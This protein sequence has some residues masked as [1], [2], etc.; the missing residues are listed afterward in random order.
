MAWSPVRR[1]NAGRFEVD[2]PGVRHPQFLP[3]QLRHL[4][5]IICFDISSFIWSARVRASCTRLRQCSGSSMNEFAIPSLA[6]GVFQSIKDQLPV[7][8]DAKSSLESLQHLLGPRGVVSSSLC[9][10]DDFTVA[11][12]VALH[13]AIC[14]SAWAKCSCSLDASVPSPSLLLRPHGS[15]PA[16][17]GS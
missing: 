11:G 2:H 7:L 1:T 3:P 5:S 8:E 12:D 9:F 15:P 13:S 10:P 6:T 4:L 17:P 14:R 16:H